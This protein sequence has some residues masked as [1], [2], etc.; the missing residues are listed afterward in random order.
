MVCLVIL[1]SSLFAAFSV[2]PMFIKDRDAN[3]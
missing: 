3:S 2:M 1:V